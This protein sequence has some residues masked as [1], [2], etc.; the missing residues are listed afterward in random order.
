MCRVRF[1]D[2]SGSTLLM[3]PVFVEK[4]AAVSYTGPVPDKT[5]TAQ[6]NYTF[7]GW[8]QEKNSDGSNL[9]EGLNQVETN[10]DLYAAF[11]ATLRYYTI[12]FVNASYS[13]ATVLQSKSTAYGETPVYAGQTPVYN[14]SASDVDDWG[15]FIEWTP[16]IV[17]VEG[18]ATYTAKFK[19]LASKT[20]KLIAKTI[21][22]AE[23]DIVTSIGVSAFLF[24]RSLTS[25][26]LPVATSIGVYAF[27]S[28]SRLTTM[29]IG[30]KSDTVCTLSGTSAIPSNVTKIYVPFPLVDAYKTATNWSSF[31]S[32]IAAYEE[33]VECLSLSI[34]ADT[35]PWYATTTTVHVTATCKYNVGGVSQGD[36]TKVFTWDVTSDAFERNSGESQRNV[37]VNFEFL[38]V[39]ASTTMVQD[40]YRT[41]LVG[42]TIFY[43][44]SSAD[45]VYEFYDINGELISDV[46]VGDKPYS[47][48]VVTPGSK[49]KYYV[50][51]DEL[52]DSLRWTYYKDGSYV[53]TS[54]GTGTAIG[55]GKSNTAT[56]LAADEGAYIT[57][58]SN[59]YPTI[60]Y[61]LQQT[62][63]ALTGGNNDWFIPSY[64]EIEE[65]RLA[66]NSGSITGGAIAGS[67]YNT[68]VF[69]SKYLWSSSEYSSQYAWLWTYYNQGWL[70][71]TKN[72]TNSVFFA[73][74]F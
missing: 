71:S 26:S 20:R 30:T 52:Y 53:Y 45:G 57:A 19:S 25:V 63:D 66:V 72:N 70:S 15:E 18:D 60:W 12:K 48:K 8:S 62:R 14:P 27:Q 61:K 44:D 22:V 35:V 67:S 21:R 3:D 40:K 49:D 41:D 34:T 64:G 9:Y 65:L 50:L 5:D 28:C 59:G 1:Y 58:D 24:C 56:V 6:Y 13:P 33:P 51:H 46:A 55:T 47:Y 73:R 7:V 31:S 16:Q 17:P 36:A 69:K 68:S 38:G 32:K 29:Y 11:S 42:G 4:G 54:L 37:T 10:L 2:E 23:S 74:A 39:S 43:I